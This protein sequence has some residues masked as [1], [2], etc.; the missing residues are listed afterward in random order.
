[1]C[2]GSR[3]TSTRSS[4]QHRWRE[5]SAH[6]HRAA[7]AAPRRSVGVLGG[8]DDAEAF[9][10]D[11]VLLR[12]FG[13]AGG[14]DA[15]PVAAVLALPALQRSVVLALVGGECRVAAGERTQPQFGRAH[16]DARC[17]GAVARD[18]VRSDARHEI[19][20]S[21][22]VGH[23]LCRRPFPPRQ[24]DVEEFVGEPG[25]VTEVLDGVLAPGEHRF[26]PRGAVGVPHRGGSIA[27]EGERVR[28]ESGF[29]HP[30]ILPRRSRAA[31]RG[32]ACK[33]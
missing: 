8:P 27:V 31:G 19:A 29:C 25:V 24:H 16:D 2:A 14:G 12:P 6:T 30:Q 13:S 7:R 3:P 21:D 10:D 18:P 28:G 26:G 1:M 17:A 15:R 33:P 11:L 9:E 32:A 23:E 5:R 20:P 22:E 4:W